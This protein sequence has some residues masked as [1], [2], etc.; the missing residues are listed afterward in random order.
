LTYEFAIGNHK[1]SGAL[2]A[3]ATHRIVRPIAE[4]RQVDHVIF[5]GGQLDGSIALA[6]DHRVSGRN[7]L[8]VQPKEDSQILGVV[9]S[10]ARA[11][12]NAVVVEIS[13]Y[14]FS[15]AFVFFPTQLGHLAGYELIDDGNV[16]S[17]EGFRLGTG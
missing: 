15:R 9:V 14:Y 17:V 10:S 3:W 7:E 12:W 13:R 6:T 11:F 4:R 2:Y 8:S 1:M 5:C 16:S